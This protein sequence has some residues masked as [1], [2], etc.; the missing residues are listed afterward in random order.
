MK[1]ILEK[2]KYK[3]KK[4][5]ETPYDKD[6]IDRCIDGIYT[7]DDFLHAVDMLFKNSREKTLKKFKDKSVFITFRNMGKE[8]FP[9]WLNDLSDD[10]QKALKE[11]YRIIVS[12]CLRDHLYYKCKHPDILELIQAYHKEAI[13]YSIIS[14]CIKN[15][16]DCYKPIKKHQL[17]EF[18]NNSKRFKELCREIFKKRKKFIDNLKKHKI[19]IFDYDSNKEIKKDEKK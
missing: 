16:L 12:Y 10:D 17:L 2:I 5:E 14:Y 9:K 8:Q 3:Y 4:F 6:I 18:L 19:S 11:N 7:R 15:N 1:E 13:P